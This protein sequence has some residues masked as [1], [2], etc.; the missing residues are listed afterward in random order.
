MFGMGFFGQREWILEADVMVL[1]FMFAMDL[2]AIP[3]QLEF[4]S[5][6]FFVCGSR[7]LLQ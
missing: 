2:I 1:L 3:Q 7:K 5:V 6:C 4:P